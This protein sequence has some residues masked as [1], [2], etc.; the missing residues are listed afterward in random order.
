MKESSNKTN[1][2]DPEEDYKVSYEEI[3]YDESKF[4]EIKNKSDGK[5]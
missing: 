2:E 1:E 5:L 3:E 4:D